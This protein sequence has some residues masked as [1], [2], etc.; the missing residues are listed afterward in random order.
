[1]W[2]AT[3]QEVVQILAPVLPRHPPADAKNGDE[4]RS[5][6]LEMCG[7][8]ARI[9]QNPQ[10]SATYKDLESKL[11]QREEDVTMLNRR[12][13]EIAKDLELQTRPGQ[14]G[15]RSV[16]AQRLNRI[17]R[18]LTAK[19]HEQGQ[20]LDSRMEVGTH[21]SP[22][23]PKARQ[24]S[25]M[26]LLSPSFQQE[27]EGGRSADETKFGAAFLDPPSPSEE[28]HRS[29]TQPTK[30]KGRARMESRAKDR[31]E[32]MPSPRMSRPPFSTNRDDRHS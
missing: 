22:R 23:S 21:L 18:I 15:D 26:N 1:L 19:I 9:A 12:C 8:A 24:A 10:E 17:H 32:E 6:L 14:R 30:S 16:L 29:T 31:P 20:I 5:A 13:Q 2:S 7:Q 3:F 11:E 4:K 25:A 28:A 27:L